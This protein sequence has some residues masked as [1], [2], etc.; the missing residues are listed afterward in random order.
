M[1]DFIYVLVTLVSFGGLAALV[2]VIDRRLAAADDLEEPAAAHTVTRGTAP[3]V[4]A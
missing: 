3:E 2:G 4:E 1:S